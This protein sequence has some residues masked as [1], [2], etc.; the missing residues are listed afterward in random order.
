MNMARWKVCGTTVVV[1]EYNAAR[2]NFQRAR[3]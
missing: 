2:R 3:F 1:P